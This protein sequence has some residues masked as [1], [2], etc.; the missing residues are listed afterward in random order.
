[1]D[2]RRD[3][4]REDVE[5]RGRGSRRGIGVWNWSG[6]RTKEEGGRE[7]EEE[8]KKKGPTCIADSKAPAAA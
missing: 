1:M 8:K 6:E 4:V 7:E 5:G 3:K 2:C